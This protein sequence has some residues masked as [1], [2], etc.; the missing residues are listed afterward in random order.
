M[1][2]NGIRY[3]TQ[4]FID[5]A[6]EIHGTLYNYDN[7]IYKNSHTKVTIIC[8]IHGEFLQRP[9]D[10]LSQKQGCPKCSHNQTITHEEYVKRSKLKHGDKFQ[11]I[12]TYK[13]GSNP[14]TIECRDHGIFTLSH[15]VVHLRGNGGCP[16][17]WKQLRLENLKPGNIS[18]VEKQ[19]LDSLNVPLRQYKI[20][21]NSNTFIVDGYNPETN[22]IYECYGSYWH[23]NPEKYSLTDFNTKIGK[24]FGELYNQTIDREN[25]L[26]EKYNLITKWV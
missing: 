22:T 5:K 23:G 21:M 19:W 6:I 9:C 26:K 1:K 10:H 16:Q 25:Q 17:C 11:I 12:S 4:S 13:S 20:Q 8:P 14:I 7:V 24:T 3:N 15:P 2:K 18:K